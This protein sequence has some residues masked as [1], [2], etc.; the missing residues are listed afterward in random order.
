MTDLENCL[1]IC[2]ILAETSAC[3]AQFTDV[4]FET[5]LSNSLQHFLHI[6]SLKC[7]QKLCLET[8]AQK[9]DLFGILPVGFSKSHSSIAAASTEQ[10]CVLVVTLLAPITKD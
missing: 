2:I 9:R 1:Y 5:A 7:E 10:T 3:D 4:E 6:S 8:V